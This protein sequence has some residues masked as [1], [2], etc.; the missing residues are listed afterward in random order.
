MVAAV[1]AW[2]IV[3]TLQRYRDDRQD[4]SRLLSGQQPNGRDTLPVCRCPVGVCYLHPGCVT[5]SMREVPKSW[6]AAV[7]EANRLA[8]DQYFQEERQERQAL[9]AFIEKYRSK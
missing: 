2:C 6:S 8:V 4:A 7:D 9:R 3:R 1:V 5:C